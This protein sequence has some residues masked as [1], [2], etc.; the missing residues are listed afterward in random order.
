MIKGSQVRV[1]AG[2]MGE[3]YSPRSTSV[4]TLYFGI[5]STPVLPQQHIKDPGHFAK[6]ADS[7]LQLNMHAPYVC[8]FASSDV[9]WCMVAWCTQNAPQW[10]HLHVTPTIQQ[11]NSAVSTQLQWIF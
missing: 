10:Q 11:P 8:G 5:H 1:P 3:C 7:R 6:C 4:L 2:A 9:T